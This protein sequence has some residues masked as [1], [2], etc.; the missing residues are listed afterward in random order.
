[1]DTFEEFWKRVGNPFG[2]RGAAEGKVAEVIRLAFEGD[3]ASGTLERVAVGLT[4]ISAVAVA[5]GLAVTSLMGLALAA[6][7]LYVVLTKV[8]G[9]DIR[10]DPASLFGGAWQP[11]PPTEA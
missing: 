3:R 5:G 7:V 10:L 4:G 9:L 6:A 11:K 8:F 2:R 1:M